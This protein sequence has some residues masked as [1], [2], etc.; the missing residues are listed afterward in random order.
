MKKVLTILL[1]STF[2]ATAQNKMVWADKV[3]FTDGLDSL[4]IENYNQIL[5]NPN[6]RETFSKSAC[7][8]K[9]TDTKKT[10]TTNDY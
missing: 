4:E 8:F 2:I 3:L 10:N 1:L 5:G 6:A 9:K 7:T